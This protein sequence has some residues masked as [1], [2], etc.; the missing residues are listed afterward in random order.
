MLATYL[1]HFWQAD[2]GYIGQAIFRVKVPN[3]SHMASTQHCMK[4]NMSSEIV[5]V[6]F[7]DHLVLDIKYFY[8]L[9]AAPE[10]TTTTT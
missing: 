9:F 8:F 5:A 1:E 7:H 6:N 3:S 10:T 2:L 4:E